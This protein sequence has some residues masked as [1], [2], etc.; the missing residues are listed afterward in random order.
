MGGWTLSG[1]LVR[2]ACHGLTRELTIGNQSS[3]RILLGKAPSVLD[4]V[5]ARGGTVVMELVASHSVVD[6][7]F[8]RRMVRSIFGSS[9]LAFD[10]SSFAAVDAQRFSGM[11]RRCRAPVNA[12]LNCHFFAD[13]DVHHLTN[14]LFLAPTRLLV[15]P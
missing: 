12:E 8:G 2:H 14:S 13:A 4:P 6:I 5:S 11:S 3:M 9:R 1:W 10:A 15:A 7:G